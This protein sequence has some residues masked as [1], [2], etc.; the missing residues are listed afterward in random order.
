[1]LEHI[2]KSRSQGP[3]RIPRAR[4]SWILASTLLLAA[5]GST[6]Q[7]PAAPSLSPSLTVTGS[8]TGA[9]SGTTLPGVD[10]VVAGLGATTSAA[11][12]SF[13][14]GTAKATG[15]RVTLRSPSTIERVTGVKV[16][17]PATV[18]LIPTSFDIAAFDQMA[19]GNEGALHRWVSAPRLIVQRRVLAFSTTSAASYVATGRLLSDQEVASLVA[20]L[21]SALPIVSGN[22][23]AAFAEVTIQS[24]A[25]GEAVT[26]ASQGA[27][28]VARYEGLEAST[29]FAGY[30]RW[31]WNGEGQLTRAIL[32]LDRAYEESTTFGLRLLRTH[33]F[34][35]AYGYNHATG[36]S[37]FMNA[38]VAIEPNAIDRDIARLAFQRPPLNVSPDSDPQSFSTNRAPATETWAGS[39]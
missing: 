5:C 21:S 28:H 35:H 2:R 1:M 17:V 7:T 36:R 23:H 3:G 24:A 20:D 16:G 19:R 8:V 12:G 22:T 6:D 38:I 29:T 37:S 27:V 34:G 15:Y 13:S 4:T 9:L 30:T 33:E 10:I 32:M 18:S 31:A 11:D 39:P 26:V 14:L 25:E